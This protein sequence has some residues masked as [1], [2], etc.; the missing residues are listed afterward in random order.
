M[1]NNFSSFSDET[2]TPTRWMLLTDPLLNK[3]K[4]IIYK[5][6]YPEYFLEVNSHYTSSECVA[7]DY[8]GM[9]FYID[10][11]RDINNFGNPSHGMLL[12]MLHWYD[13]LKISPSLKKLS[14]QMPEQSFFFN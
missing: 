6:D 8:Q 14:V 10:I 12:E 5:I 4:V 1:E 13:S 11:C 2:R 3:P 9:T 7:V